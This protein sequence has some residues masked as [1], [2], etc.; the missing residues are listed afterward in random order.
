MFTGMDLSMSTRLKTRNLDWPNWKEPDSL[1]TKWTLINI[2]VKMTAM[3][4]F[5]FTIF[6]KTCLSIIY[7]NV[8]QDRLKGW[9]EVSKHHFIVVTGWVTVSHH[10]TERITKQDVFQEPGTHYNRTLLSLFFYS[11]T[12][13]QA[14]HS[15]LHT[16]QPLFLTNHVPV[17]ATY[18]TVKQLSLNI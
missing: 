11:R 6:C 9:T 5:C 8:R 2:I 18:T 13:S 3:N 15:L 10:Y 14:S 7:C 1:K 16:L 12:L 4:K 17:S